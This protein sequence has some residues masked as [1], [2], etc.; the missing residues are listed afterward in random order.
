[1]T[2]GSHKQRSL[3]AEQQLLAIE[4][5]CI[6]RELAGRADEPVTRDHDRQRVARV[7]AADRSRPVREPQASRLLGIR[8]GLAVGDLGERKPGAPLE[9]RPGQIEWKLELP[10]PPRE[11][12]G[13][14][15]TRFLD[16]RGRPARLGA[17]PFE[18]LQTALGGDD[19]QRPEARQSS[20]PSSCRSCTFRSSPPA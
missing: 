5:A 13:Q 8:A 18:P 16:E 11:V 2:S 1:V 19:P 4:P 9:G 15:D 3:E 20:A 14:L 6:T 17:A 7:R 12:L 10:P